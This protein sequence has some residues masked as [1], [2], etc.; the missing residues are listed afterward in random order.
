MRKVCKSFLQDISNF[1]YDANQYV[2]LLCGSALQE[3]NPRDTDI[4]IY[5]QVELRNFSRQL[6]RYLQS[7]DPTARLAYYK[8]LK[9]FS[10]KY[11]SYSVH[12]VSSEALHAYIDTISNIKNFVDVNIFDVK[13]YKQTVYRKWIE[14]TEYLYG[15]IN[16]RKHILQKL[17]TAQKQIPYQKAIQVLR[18]K[19]KNNISYFYEKTDNTRVGIAGEIIICQIINNLVCLSY[20]MNHKFYG[21]VKYIEQD[22]MGFRGHDIFSGNCLDLLRGINRKDYGFYNKI[23]KKILKKLEEIK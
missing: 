5:A 1:K 16:I 9:L 8:E 19:L 23:Y 18:E 20:L 14:D 3:E 13:L 22:L 4:L 12:I 11:Q 10:I 7:I 6:L 15:N 17:C 21:T 2:C